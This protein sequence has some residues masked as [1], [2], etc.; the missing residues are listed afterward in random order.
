MTARRYRPGRPKVPHY[1]RKSVRLALSVPDEDCVCAACGD[2]YQAEPGSDPTAC[3]HGCAQQLLTILAE[4]VH[5]FTKRA[6][7]KRAATK[8]EERR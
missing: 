7:A 4:F 8:R 6:P 1:V 2:Y 5:E 3:C